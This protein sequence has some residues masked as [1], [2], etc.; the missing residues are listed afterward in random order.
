[1][2][3]KKKLNRSGTTSVVVA[4]KQK[5]RYF[6][7][8]TIGISSDPSTINKF[9]EE[10]KQW[11]LNENKKRQPE[12]DLF[13][14]EM[15]KLQK[16][17]EAIHQFLSCI[18]NIMLNGTDL[19]LDKVFDCIGFNEIEDDIFRHLVKSRL[20]YPASKSATVEYLKNHFDEDVNLSKIYRYLDKLSDHHHEL[21]QTISVKHTMEVLGG[22]IGIL[23]Y[24]VTTLHFEA[25]KEDDLR[26]TGFSKNGRH[27]S[28]QIVL[29]LLVSLNGY[30]LAY[31]IHE[32][33]KYEG[34]TMLPIIEEFVQ[35]YQLDDFV[36]VADAGLMN[37][38]NI[39]ELEYLGYQ[40]II[41]AKIKNETSNIKRFILSQSKLDCQI[42]E[43]DKGNGRR[44]LVG[45][46]DERAKKMHTIATKD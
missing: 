40:Y 9:V 21:V 36:V 24:D 44:L 35:K 3:I 19:I 38:T 23:F 7:H 17:R 8:I 37:N 6:E 45:Y 46:T 10:G 2:Y 11:I 33:N 4:E 34:H 22:K 28:P 29:G 41:G 30:P 39:E 12:I 43:I 1:M 15:A 27:S 42:F 14:E 18:D 31:C 5:G 16:E 26:K 13:G 25:D 32:G 20:S